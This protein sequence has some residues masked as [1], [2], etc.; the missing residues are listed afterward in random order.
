MSE[1]DLFKIEARKI[2]V[3]VS[4]VETP[5]GIQFKYGNT[6]DM[7]LLWQASANRQGYKLVPV[8]P[9]YDMYDAFYKEHDKYEEGDVKPFKESYKAMLDAVGN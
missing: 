8:E 1:R 9:T 5:M 4:E 2:G 7:F 3:D 6:R